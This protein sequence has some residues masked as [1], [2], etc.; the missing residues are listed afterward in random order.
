MTEDEAIQALRDIDCRD[1]KQSNID[2]VQVLLEVV[3][4]QVFLE[5]TRVM[6][7]QFTEFVKRQ[8]EQK[9]KA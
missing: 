6:S 8:N 3:P 2:A 4:T 7:R 9:A 1:M 5:Y